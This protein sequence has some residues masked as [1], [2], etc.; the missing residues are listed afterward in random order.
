LRRGAFT[1]IE[2]MAVVA[3][4]GLIAG[5]TAWSLADDAQRYALQDVVD[6]LSHADRMTRMASRRLGEPCRLRFDLDTQQVRRIGK[7]EHAS[8]TL[9]IPAGFRI[10]RIVTPHIVD[11]VGRATRSGISKRETGRIDIAFSTGGH[12][13]SYAVRVIGEADNQGTWLVVSGLSGQ[14]TLDHEQDEIENLFAQLASSG[15]DAD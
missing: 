3:L 15:P 7:N 6:R 5:A 14:L 8:H 11:D 4:L 9:N 12:S 1:L 10:D 2:V 13:I